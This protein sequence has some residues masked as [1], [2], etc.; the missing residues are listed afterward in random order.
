MATLAKL[1]VKL[2]TDV[3][4]FE[5][6][7]QA[8]YKKL[9]KI[10]D[11]MTKVGGVITAGVTLP[12]I[13]AGAASVKFASDLNDSTDMIK[14]AFGESQAVV[15]KWAQSAAINLGLSKSAAEQAAGSFGLF[16]TN[17]GVAQNKAADMS[18]KLVS[19][20]VD[21]GEL[22][23]VDPSTMF[24]A[25]Q[26]ALAGRGGELKRFGIII[27]DARIKAKAYE[28]GIY[29]GAGAMDDATRATAAYQ[30]ILDQTTKYQGFFAS[31]TN[32][33]GASMAKLKA[34]ATDVGASFGQLVI[35]VLVKFMEALIP[36]LQFLNNLPAPVKTFIIVM[37]GLAAAVGP[38]LVIAGQLIGAFTA[39]AG[40][41]GAG[42]VMAGVGTFFTATL[43]PALVGLPAALAPIGVG[44][45][46]IGFPI[47]V[48]IAAI[49]LLIFTIVQLGPAAW[50]TIQMIG[51][52]FGMLPQLINQKLT[53]VCQAINAQLKIAWGS[54]VNWVILVVSKF[55]TLPQLIGQK[56]AGVGQAIS[57]MLRNAWQTVVNW[58]KSFYQAGQALMSGFINGIISYAITVVQTV[59][60]V[61]Q[62]VIDAVK[63][64]LNL[65]SP[66]RVFAGIGK[67]MMLGLEAGVSEF[68]DRPIA[69][70]VQTTGAV[71]QAVSGMRSGGAGGRSINVGPI[72]IQGD[73]SAGQKA[74]LAAWFEDMVENKLVEALGEPA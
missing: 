70:T 15:E 59:M 7:M 42:G 19:L 73:L 3:S 50:N 25:L 65:G 64:L 23:N 29:S 30:I 69:A 32:D 33:A 9:T 6:G 51:G 43:I 60:N 10:G 58:A 27:D 68:S 45:L 66:S 4:S 12:I 47:F 41:F 34:L 31:Q 20:A 48:L 16:L 11:Q 49:G 55:G 13:A 72:T 21:L 5:S 37:L 40:L 63:K 67:N 57:G 28:M 39:I 56:L 35:P 52:I 18:T 24:D 1:I 38:V 61:I 62:S 54:I 22:K 8:S 46:A 36:I 53:G 2:I 71:M 26:S 44:F 17:M 74:S 14:M